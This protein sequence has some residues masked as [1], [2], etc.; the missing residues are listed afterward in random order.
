MYHDAVGHHTPEGVIIDHERY[1]VSPRATQRVRATPLRAEHST[2]DT[3]MCPRY[4]MYHDAA[5]HHTPEGVL[6]NL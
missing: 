3:P 4:S 5:W 6:F 1:G 2:N